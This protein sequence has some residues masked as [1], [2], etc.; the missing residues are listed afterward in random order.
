M[1]Y[2]KDNANRVHAIEDGFTHLLPE[3][4]AE[5]TE[6]EAQVLSAPQP[7][8]RLQ[9]EAAAKKQAAIALDVN[10]VAL[11]RMI[12]KRASGTEKDSLIALQT[13]LEQIP[14]VV[15][16]STSTSQTTAYALMHQA[17]LLAVA[18]FAPPIR[19]EFAAQI[20]L[21]KLTK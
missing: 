1:R 7:V 18:P 8:P 3:G 14:F 9:W 16:L 2:F 6:Q 12:A 15:D 10:I 21:L 11:G 13:T 17:Y 4:L 20:N 19:A 5:I